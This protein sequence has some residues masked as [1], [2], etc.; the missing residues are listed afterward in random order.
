MTYGTHI[1]TLNITASAWNNWKPRFNLWYHSSWSW[2]N[3]QFWTITV[4]FLYDKYS[5]A[6]MLENNMEGQAWFQR[7][8]FFWLWH[9]ETQLEWWFCSRG[10][11]LGWSLDGIWPQPRNTR[12]V[13]SESPEET[14]AR[15]WRGRIEYK[16]MAMIATLL[17]TFYSVCLSALLISILFYSSILFSHCHVKYGGVGGREEERIEADSSKSPSNALGKFGDEN[18]SLFKLFWLN[19]RYPRVTDISG[20]ALFFSLNTSSTVALDTAVEMPKAWLE[21]PTLCLD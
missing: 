15:G 21:R 13:P 19:D 10:R 9:L 8:A 11:K 3:R 4:F 5:S 17:S 20:T 7:T 2:T 18:N 16:A 12:R 14:C 1:W 6:G